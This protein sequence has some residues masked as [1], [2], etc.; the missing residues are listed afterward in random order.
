MGASG[1]VV[2]APEVEI[3]GLIV[4]NFDQYGLAAIGKSATGSRFLGN[5]IG[6]SSDGRT[7][8]PNIL[9]GIAILAGASDVS[10]G[11]TCARC[12]NLISGNSLTGNLIKYTGHGVLVGGDGTVGIRIKGNVI[13][14][15]I[16]GRSLPNDDGILIVDRAQAIIGGRDSTD[17][18]VISGNRIAGIELR[19]TDSLNTNIQGN[20]I[21]TDESGRIGV[22]NDVGVFVNDFVQDTL[23]GGSLPGESNVISG[24]RVGVAIERR[25]TGTVVQGNFIGLD[26]TGFQA[27]GNS[28][29]GVSII[30]GPKGVDLGGPLIGEGN[31]ISGNGNAIVIDGKATKEIHVQGNVIGTD[32]EGESIVPN[33]SGITVKDAVDVT[34]GGTS[35]G[36]GN[37]VVGN[38]GAGIVLDGAKQASVRS[39]WIGLQLDDV[40]AGNGVGVVLRGGTVDSQVQANRIGGNLGAGIT[41]LGDRTQRNRLTR[42]IFLTNGGVGIDLLA[43]GPT[44]NTKFNSRLLGPNQLIATPQ[45]ESFNHDGVSAT[46]T[47]VGVPGTSVEVYRVSSARKPH[48]VPHPSGFG[49][50]Q[51][52]LGA[53]FVDNDGVWKIRIVTDIDAPISALSIDSAGNTSEFGKN[54]IPVQPVVLFSGLNPVGWFSESVSASEAFAPLGKRLVAAWRFQANTQTWES[55]RPGLPIISDLGQLHPGDALWVELSEGKRFVW[56]QPDFSIGERFVNLSNGLNLVTWTGPALAVDK[57]IEPLESTVDAVFRWNRGIRRFELIMPLLPFMKESAEL[58]SSDVLWLRMSEAI[59]W[60]QPASDP[61]VQD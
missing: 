50:G 21:G 46:I 6:L 45:I 31:W 33:T 49:A 15:D 44:L 47:G 9:S 20:F 54:F 16:D 41:V 60:L 39:N 36:A 12:G 57:A 43:D 13:G 61:R 17:R 53:T 28:E 30:A 8:R 29:D 52:F 18:N 26:V 38:V 4:G 25:A 34:I 1:L 7:S 40:S 2:S 11:D 19:D 14:L 27:I 10:I 59:G 51:E 22:G 3:R 23:I 56:S 48:A 42:N 55:F 5:W 24:N 32:I 58:K 35:N 37:V